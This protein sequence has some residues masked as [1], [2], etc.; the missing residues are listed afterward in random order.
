MLDGGAGKDNLQ[1]GAG[2]DTI[3]AKDRARDL[4]NGGTGTDTAT[5]DPK[6]DKLTS[7]EHHNKK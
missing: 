3:K 2:N 7:I 4:V 1:G 6:L 5:I